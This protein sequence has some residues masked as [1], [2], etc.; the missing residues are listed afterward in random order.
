M[1]PVLI[2]IL[3]YVLAQ[4]LIVVIVARR[5]RGE[6]D[7]LL[8][9]RRFGVGLATFTIFAT[10]FGAETCIGAAGAV[11]QGGLSSSTADP[12]GYTVCLLLMG[13]VFAV[14]LWRRK[15]TTFADLFRQRFSPGVERLATLLLVPTSLMW[16]AAQ[17][18]ALG[19]VISTSSDF[20]VELAIGIAAG[21][22]ILY[23]VYGGMLADA[24]TDLIQGIMVMLGLAI[25]LVVTVNAVGGVEAAVAAIEPQRWHLFE[26]P[27]LEVMERW[28]VPILGSALAQEL[29]AVVLASHTPRVARRASLTAGGIYLVFGLI[30]VFIGLI[31][32]RLVPD[33]AQPEQLLPQ[34]AQ[35]YLST[36]PFIVFA[37]AIISAILSTVA[38]ALLAAA[39]LT[40]H[41]LVVPLRPQ[42]SAHAKVRVARICVVV[43]GVLAYVLARHAEGIYNLVEEASA[44]GSAG[45][46]VAAVIGL[47]SSFGHVRAAY[48]ALIA[49]TGTWITGDY[50]LQLPQPYLTSVAAALTAYILLALTEQ[51]APRHV[52]G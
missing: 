22:V 32:A 47:F 16:A 51:R 21:V 45:I 23:T 18:R 25:L 1:S 37:G 52:T 48:G 39:A 36:L 10:W 46:F 4:L 27:P 28:A 7:Y 35:K 12:F 13:F 34:V 9:G 2:G 41:N 30:P 20:N 5:I 33:L 31:G 38:G 11:Y 19:Q 43:G 15:L 50:L 8:A 44:F 26:G 24:V 29:I 6:N 3:A 14:P 17:I 40:S 42:L 49:G